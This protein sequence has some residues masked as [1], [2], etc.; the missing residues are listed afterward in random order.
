MVT[1]ADSLFVRTRPDLAPIRVTFENLLPVF[2]DLLVSSS[3]AEFRGSDPEERHVLARAV[4][5]AGGPVLSTDPEEPPTVSDTDLD[6]L[7]DELVLRLGD[8]QSRWRSFYA[9]MAQG[10]TPSEAVVV[11]A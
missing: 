8:D 10:L 6:E 9:L 7:L 1:L 2:G 4:V 3:L 5:Q 11:A